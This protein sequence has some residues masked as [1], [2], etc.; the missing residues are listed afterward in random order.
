LFAAAAFLAMSGAALAR[1]DPTPKPSGVVVH[2]FNAPTPAAGA[3][4]PPGWGAVLHQ[5][6]VTGDPN[7]KPGATLPKGRAGGQ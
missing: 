2:L 5:M 4:R 6:F 7:Q 1:P 3:K